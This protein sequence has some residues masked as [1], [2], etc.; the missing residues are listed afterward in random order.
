MVVPRPENFEEL[1]LYRAAR[2]FRRRLFQLGHFLPDKESFRP[3]DKMRA[4]ALAVTNNI[5][6]DFNRK[7]LPENTRSF[8][9]ARNALLLLLDD[10]NLCLDEGY[11][12]EEYLLA[13]KK[14]ARE[15][16][17]KLENL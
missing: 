15:L 3:A 1:E 11:Y 17:E 16:L 9:G 2:E 12:S 13:L 8:Q 4:L 10:L 6:E 7:D 14:E 5:V